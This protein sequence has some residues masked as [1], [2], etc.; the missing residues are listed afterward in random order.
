MTRPVFS[1]GASRHPYRMLDT[2][3]EGAGGAQRPRPGPLRP[4]R[5]EKIGRCPRPLRTVRA[6]FTAYRS[7][8][9]NAPVGDAVVPRM[10]RGHGR[11]DGTLGAAT[12]GFLCCLLLRGSAR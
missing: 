8:H 9:P 6:I 12:P 7:S 11:F 4:T 1:V 5:A 3:A 2:G 10:A